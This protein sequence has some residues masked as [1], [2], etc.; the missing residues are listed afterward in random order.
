[1]NAS[2]RKTIITATLITAVA[3]V[4]GLLQEVNVAAGKEGRAL[5]M[6]DRQEVEK[7]INNVFGWAV[8]KDFN[9]FFSTIADDSEFI[10]VTPYKRVKFG[11]EDVKKD[12]AF[13][14]NPDFRAIRHELRDLRLTF[15]RSGDVAWFYCVLDDINELKGQPANWENVRWTGVVEKRDGRWRV[16]QQHFSY[17]Q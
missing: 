6:K 7:A 4:I 13:W 16:V 15:S 14:S 8:T 10:S 17:A 1:M 9:L 3:L 2:A 5:Q 11:V 12:T